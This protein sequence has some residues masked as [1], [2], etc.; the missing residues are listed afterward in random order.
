MAS[1]RPRKSA[2]KDARKVSDSDRT[3]ST[4]EK[5]YRC[6]QKLE[7]K[8]EKLSS[9]M[10]GQGHTR[11]EVIAALRRQVGSHYPQARWGGLHH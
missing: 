10:Y 9:Q 2:I 3:L 11:S 1:K 8:S 7:I 4:V 5:A 6:T